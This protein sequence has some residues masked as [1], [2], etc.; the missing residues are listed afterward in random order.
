MYGSLYQRQA[1]TPAHAHAGITTWSQQ[2]SCTNPQ[3]AS[4]VLGHLHALCCAFMNKADA[5]A[6]F[7]S[8]AILTCPKLMHSSSAATGCCGRTELMVGASEDAVVVVRPL[9]VVPQHC[10]GLDCL[11]EVLRGA[12]LVGRPHV[13][14]VPPLGGAPEGCLCVRGGQRV[15]QLLHT[16][17]VHACGTASAVRQYCDG[18]EQQLCCTTHFRTNAAEL[19]PSE[20]WR[21]LPTVLII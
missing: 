3:Y 17:T 14:R 6:C 18:M 20:N 13:V 16:R 15:R 9:A 1:S 2:T 5:V 4:V 10:V 21:A 8:C 11:P 7:L 12:L 19:I